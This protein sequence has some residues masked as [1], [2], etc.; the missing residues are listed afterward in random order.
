MKSTPFMFRSM[1]WEAGS[2]SRLRK[3]RNTAANLTQRQ[4][5]ETQ[6]RLV[7]AVNSVCHVY[8]R[9]RFDQFGDYIC[10]EEEAAHSLISRP[11]QGRA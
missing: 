1:A 3:N 5:T 2:T 7:S 8:F 11:E 10:I 6:Q 9:P 4:N